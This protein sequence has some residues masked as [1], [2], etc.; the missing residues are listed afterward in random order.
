MEQKI[1][2]GQIRALE[3]CPHRDAVVGLA[4][5]LREAHIPFGV[6]TNANLDQLKNYRAVLLP[7]VSGD[8]RRAGGAVPSNL[9]KRAACCM[10]E[11]DPRHSTGS[12]R[13]GR[14]SCW[15]T[16]SASVIPGP[17]AAS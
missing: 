2:V 13:T 1:R 12:T 16:F 9:W 7:N 10:R 17:W 3:D 15:R 6:V 14:A 8:D 11:L 5:I 4:R